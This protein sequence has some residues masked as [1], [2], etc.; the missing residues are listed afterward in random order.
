MRFVGE[1][2]QDGRAA[3]ELEIASESL[4]QSVRVWIDADSGDL[5]RIAYDG[6]AVQGE[7][8]PIVELFADFRT[9]D[10][11]RLPFRTTISQRGQLMTT[12]QL[13]EARFNVGFTA[14]ELSKRP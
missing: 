7:P 8:P 6:V 13:I 9:V 11:V 4:G 2:R 3:A 10:G 5:F 1:S 12:V 14:D